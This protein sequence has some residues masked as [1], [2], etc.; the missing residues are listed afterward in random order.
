MRMILTILA[1]TALSA[2][3]AELPRPADPPP[4]ATAALPGPVSYEVSS[5][6]RLLLHWR[7]D[8]DG[9][10]EIW[11]GEG[12]GKGRGAVRKYRLRMDGAA[13]A[14][15]AAKAEPLRLATVNGIVCQHEITDLPYG[16][17]AWEYPGKKHSY[18]FNAGCRSPAANAA[19]DDL[20]AASDVV[21]KMATIEAE[22]YAIDPGPS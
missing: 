7:V 16:T 19:M 21:E 15:F 20:R 22:P 13:L 14:A 1:V 17:I 11:R 2:C 12:L 6:G 4:P 5:W 8:P 9:G 3:A 18:A 10:G